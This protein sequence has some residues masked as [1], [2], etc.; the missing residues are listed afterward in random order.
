MATLKNEQLSIPGGFQYYV[1]D[2]KWSP[3]PFSS[4]DSI[5]TQLIQHLQ[6]RP[7]IVAKHGWSLDPASVRRQVVA[8]QVALC[9]RNG[10]SDYI[11][12]G[13]ETVPFPIPSR[14]LF[15]KAKAVAAGVRTLVS[16]A[17]DGAP[18]VLVT[19]ANMRAE[20]CVA[21]PLNGKGGL[22]T[23]FTVPAQNAIKAQL[24][25]KRTMKL[26]TPLDDRLGVCTACDCPLPLKIWLPLDHILA[27]MPAESKAALHPD[28]WILSEEKA[29]T[30]KL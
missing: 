30:P 26:E 18:T 14:S 4:I 28:C 8:Y 23:Y 11:L 9:V 27:K 5:T 3:A 15:A 13:A 19:T 29:A 6:A 2:S 12:G 10:W 25:R 16:W 21:C 7:D 1:P 17:D 20:V 22:E 24:E